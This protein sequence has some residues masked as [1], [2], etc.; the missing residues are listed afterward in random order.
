MSPRE[1]AERESAIRDAVGAIDADGNGIL[2]EDEVSSFLADPSGAVLEDGTTGQSIETTL[3]ALLRG[4]ACTACGP[5]PPLHSPPPCPL[6]G[7]NE[8]RSI[9]VDELVLM[10]VQRWRYHRVMERVFQVRRPA[11]RTRAP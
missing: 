5:L 10:G 1:A 11:T 6:V 7:A 3:F 9:S 4:G 2:S 8:S